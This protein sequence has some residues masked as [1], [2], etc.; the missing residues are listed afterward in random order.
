MAGGKRDVTCDV[1]YAVCIDRVK[2]LHVT[3]GRLC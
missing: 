1:R 3:L 2:M